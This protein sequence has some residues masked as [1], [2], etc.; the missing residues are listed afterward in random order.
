[1]KQDIFTE[2]VHVLKNG[3]IGVLATDT[4]YGIV[5]SALVSDTVERIYTV[6]KRTPDKA[7]II[8]ISS[9]DELK[10]FSIDIC[11]KAKET[12]KKYWPGPVS[13]IFSC[14]DK[15]FE[16]LYRG[17]GSLAFRVPDH[18]ELIRLLKQTGPLIAP[19]ANIEGKPFARTIGEARE[20]FGENVDFYIDS[21]NISQTLPSTIL[22]FENGKMSLVRK[23][24]VPFTA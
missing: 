5:G 4:L 16:Y 17:E 20:Y 21:G 23:G 7:S 22:R 15:K 24:I 8:L 13:I 6:R 12:L 3:G 18:P 11:P 10:R 9:E 19:S 1:M 14:S 2:V